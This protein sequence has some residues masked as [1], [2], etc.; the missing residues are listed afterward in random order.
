MCS[1]GRIKHHLKHNLWR[2]ESSI[3]FVG[4]QAEGTLGRRIKEG[5]KSVKLFG[6]EIQVNA[7]IYT[8]DGFSGH[9]DKEGI[10]WWLEGFENK[11]KK[12]FIVHG[13]EEAS[14]EISKK[15]EEELNIVTYIPELGDTL[16]VEGEVVISKGKVSLEERSIQYNEIE[17]SLEKLKSSLYP[18]LQKL[19]QKSENGRENG[20]LVEIKNK[21]IRLQKESAELNMLLTSKSE[22]EK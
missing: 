4:Y 9:A 2:N 17:K 1:A 19:E 13:E 12:I 15:I 21:L 3:V 10:M 18:A 20:E 14:R 7:K 6:E 16:I 11:P 5:E 22:K 8:L